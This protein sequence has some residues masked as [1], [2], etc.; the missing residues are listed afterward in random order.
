MI[1]IAKGTVNVKVIFRE[2]YTPGE[3]TEIEAAQKIR[4]IL[5]TSPQYRRAALVWKGAKHPEGKSITHY[6]TVIEDGT[7]RDISVIKSEGYKET[8]LFIR[9]GDKNTIIS[10]HES[11]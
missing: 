2:V 8:E 9:D 7:E 6:F 5:E 10:R 4:A 3:E 11:I 1:T